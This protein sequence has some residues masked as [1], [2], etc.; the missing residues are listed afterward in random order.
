[1]RPTVLRLRYNIC[2]NIVKPLTTRDRCSWVELIAREDRQLVTW[3]M[4]HAWATPFCQTLEMVCWH[5]M[6]HRLPADAGYWCCTLANVSR[7]CALFAECKA[8]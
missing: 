1:M 5:A 6:V 7:Q 3:F 8:F 2:D 4:S